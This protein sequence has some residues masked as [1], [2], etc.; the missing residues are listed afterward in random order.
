MIRSIR[1]IRHG[2][3]LAAVGLAVAAIVALGSGQVS[4]AKPPPTTVDLRIIGMNDLHGNLQPPAGS[5]G[6]VI[7]PG[8][9]T[10][11]AGGVAFMATHV[12]Q[13]RQQVANSVVVAQ[14]DLIGASP[15]ASALFHDEPTIDV[16]NSVGLSVSAAGNHEFD[17][18]YDELLRMQRGGCHPV[19]G[20]QF[21][22][23]YEG[24]EFPY[25]A[26]NV[27]FKSNGLPA[28]PP[29]WLSFVQGIPVGYIGMPL[30][31]TPEIVSAEGIKNLNFG[32]EVAAA[33]KYADLLDQ[34][35]VKTIIMMMH[36]GDQVLF[37]NPPDACGIV[38]GVG[39]QIAEQVSPKI[40][41]VLAAHT[42]QQFNCMV[43]DPAGQP[44]PYIQG[45]SFG[46]IL[47]VIDL[48]ID[49]KT[50]DVVRAQTTATNHI[51]TRD[52]AEDP[53]VKALVD[54][55]VTK[56]APIA[57][58][59]IGTITATIVRAA[60]ASGESP[61]GNLIADA[62]LEQ[63]QVAGA[64]IALMNPGG[65]RA[66]LT[67]ASSPIGEGDGVVTYGEAFTV[68]PFGNVMTTMTLTGAQIKAVLEQQWQPTVTRILQPSASLHYSWS[69]SA[70]T[71]SKVSGITINGTPIDPAASY[72]VSVNN[73]LADGGDGFTEL[74]NGTNRTGGLVDI[75]AFVAYMQGHPNVAPP[76]TDRITVL[77]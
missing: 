59:P 29:V 47:S 68:Q 18:G 48:K 33:N 39:R 9:G 3:L 52:V 16:L 36:Q 74:R 24:S 43:N 37:G 19:D 35:G 51:V 45:L 77:P 38:P 23:T 13:L 63:T 71:G 44:R 56:S 17:E 34:F 60:V 28:L 11:D 8:G 50:K 31:G 49:Q 54:E 76:A 4:A 41:A 20:C 65:V 21:H 30:E 69:Q 46:R 42:H 70:P 22:E 62:Q 64:Q 5:S 67:Y 7:L 73:F 2:R 61:L 66:D 72:R 53:D 26:A 15:L 40:D 75:D 10:V 1:S 27:T 32:G 6:R 25:L 57:N 58:R 14:G 12:R 55:A